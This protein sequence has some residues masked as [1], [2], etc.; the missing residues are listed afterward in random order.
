MMQSH[1]AH[2]PYFEIRAQIK[3]IVNSGA[4]AGSERLC[5]FLTWTVEESAG[6][7]DNI[8]QLLTGNYRKGRQLLCVQL[9]S[10]RY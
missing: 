2:L 4:F 7:V 8:R 6:Q 3:R 5:R 1:L 9:L 10:D